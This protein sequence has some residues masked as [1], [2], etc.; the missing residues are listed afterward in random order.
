MRVKLTLLP[1]NKKT[2]LPV[3]YNYFLTSLIYK[4]IKN[5]SKDYSMFLHDKGYTLGKSK[6]GFKLF[7]YSMLMSQ[8]AR[9]KGNNIFFPNKQFKQFNRFERMEQLERFERLYSHVQWQISSPV[10]DFIQHLITGIFAE[11]QKIE[12]RLGSSSFN[13]LNGLNG[14]LKN[15]FLIKR[16]ETLQKPEFKE[17]M[18]F[19]CLSPITV[20]KVISFN[21]SSSSNSSSGLNGL[22]G[23]SGLSG[24]LS[25][26]YLR[27]WEEG[28]SET[29]KN[30]LVKKYRLVTG[31]DIDA[32][33]LEIKIDTEYMNKKSGKIIK[34]INF[35]GTNIIG[36]MAPFE[37]T[38]NPEL[39]EIGYEAGFG[40]KGSMGFGM[41]KITA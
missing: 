10:D 6:K 13:S 11:G 16:V 18:R 23:L 24:P 9:V 38:G 7:T 1:L 37:V 25:C 3:N 14:S 2:V 21:R 41:V 39:I 40:E 31:K 27:P 28:F 30:N 5:S 29:I 32:P 12:I 22:N 17:I 35:K 20:S 19:T 36:F 26:H 34:N 8:A 33:D 4:I 15:G